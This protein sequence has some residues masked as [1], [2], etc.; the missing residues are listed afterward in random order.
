M[1]MSVIG[2]IPVS[3]TATQQGGDYSASYGLLPTG[4][5]PGITGAVTGDNFGLVVQLQLMF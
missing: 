2:T 5:G 3:A 4:G 1:K